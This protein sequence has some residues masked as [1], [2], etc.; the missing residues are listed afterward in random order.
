MKPLTLT[1][2]GLVMTGCFPERR[3]TPV[4]ELR[5]KT[6]QYEFTNVHAVAHAGKV[7]LIDSGLERNVGL[8]EDGLRAGGLSPSDVVAVV[9]THGHA[10]H[11][12][13]ARAFQAKYG[14]KV[15]AGRG[16]ASML[17]A[18][19]NEPLCPTNDDARGRLEKDQAETYQPLTAT[20]FVEGPG[21]LE[22]LTGLA[23]LDGEVIPVPGHTEGS[24][25]VRI[26][27]ALFVGDLLRGAVF[28]NDADVH[29]YMCDLE[30][31]ARDIRGLLETYPFVTTWFVGHFGPLSRQAVE[32]KFARLRR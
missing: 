23:G 1:L 11:A 13:G 32:A 14:A 31:N 16:D 12:G 22:A 9:L 4:G 5:V 15:L 6:F 19:K 26:G 20:T 29:F 10:D 7:V 27:S 2:V 3:E 24:L 28:T 8:L 25:A 30:D 18:G 17:G 21:T